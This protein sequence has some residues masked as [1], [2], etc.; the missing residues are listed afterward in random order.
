M[1]KHVDITEKIATYRKSDGEI[2]CGNGNYQ[3]QFTFDGE[4][5][6]YTVKTARFQIQNR[7]I[8]VEFTGTICKV[9][10]LANTNVVQ[11]G[12]YAG[13]PDS[14]DLCTSTPAR[15][16][17]R[18]S[19][20]CGNAKPSLENYRQYID[21]AK[22]C[23]KQ[24]EDA[25]AEAQAAAEDAKKAEGEAILY[26]TLSCKK[27]DLIDGRIAADGFEIKQGSTTTFYHSDY[28]QTV[29]FASVSLSYAFAADGV[30]AHFYD[31][32]KNL[33]GQINAQPGT[34]VPNMVFRLPY[35]CYYI[36]Y[37]VD[38]YSLNLQSIAYAEATPISQK[39]Q[40]FVQFI[41]KKLDRSA[42]SFLT[43]AT[44][45]PIVTLVDDDTG[46]VEHVEQF[47][48]MC[49]SA[50]I[51]GTF[52]AI[53]DVLTRHA[54]VTDKLKEYEEE[55]FQIVYHCQNQIPA[56]NVGST[57]DMAVAEADFVR[58]LRDMQ[59]LGFSDFQYWVSPY[60]VND[61]D[62]QDLA[63]RHGMKCLLDVSNLYNTL[64]NANRFAIHR[65]GF[66]PTDTESNTFAAL[67]DAVDAC[68]EQNGW[69]I[70]CMHSYDTGWKNTT[71]FADLIAHVNNRA[72]FLT[73][74]E[75][76]AIRKPIYEA[77]EMF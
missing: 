11:V 59:A 50:G 20:L 51:R 34:A 32:E 76:F 74:S 45:Y 39:E 15:I 1:I 38:Q 14:P 72:K 7:F 29:P 48:T 57:R 47:Y 56:Y 23:V 27:E 28:L 17:C 30:L 49:K 4:W 31:Q 19:V 68:V 35:N 8:D 36:R 6:P 9:P 65:Y 54:D 21:Q 33:V 2:I 37:S 42:D 75:A 40:L 44:E 3:I 24:A 64:Q 66:N 46:S 53:T 41:E 58:G 13:D 62:M 70:L 77:N 63:R 25:V 16:N 18:L 61:K 26:T 55:G 69:L 52:A 43:K 71:R 22:Q 60:G 10:V 5:S 12:V 67:K 73:L